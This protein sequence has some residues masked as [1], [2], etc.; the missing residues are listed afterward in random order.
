MRERDR[1]T[2]TR[3]KRC[4]LHESL[5]S[6]SLTLCCCCSDS[7]SNNNLPLEGCCCSGGCSCFLCPSALLSFAFFID[8]LVLLDAERM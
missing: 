5:P 6:L 4:L 2:E 8:F 7:R 3:T 1:D